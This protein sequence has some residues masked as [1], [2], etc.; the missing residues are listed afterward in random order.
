MLFIK[1]FS[2]N[3]QYKLTLEVIYMTLW[4]KLLEFLSSLK[5]I[6]TLKNKVFTLDRNT[7][8]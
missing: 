3:G 8:Q 6:Q 4:R 2:K 5:I 7:T 1:I